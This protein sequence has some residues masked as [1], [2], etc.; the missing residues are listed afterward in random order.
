MIDQQ[1][2]QSPLLTY[3]TPLL[4]NPTVPPA[5]SVEIV[6]A[7]SELNAIDELMADITAD[8]VREVKR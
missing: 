6:R 3:A 1:P 8:F 5:S 2:A 4:A 7:E